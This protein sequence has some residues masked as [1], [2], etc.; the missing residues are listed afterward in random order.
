MHVAHSIWGPV[1]AIGL[2]IFLKLA[3]LILNNDSALSYC[4][5]KRYACPN[6]LLFQAFSPSLFV[7]VVD[8]L[9]RVVENRNSET[10]GQTFKLGE[11]Y[12]PGIYLLE[13]IQGNQRKTLKLIKQ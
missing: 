13:A 1:K 10:E 9:G 12:R 3:I 5:F 4:F 2:C 6:T 7:R 11:N 8:V